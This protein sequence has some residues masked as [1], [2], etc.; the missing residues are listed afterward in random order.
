MET[1]HLQVPI[2][3]SQSIKDAVPFV[4]WAGG[5]RNIIT[6]LISRLPAKI[7]D[8]YEPFVG[9]GAL[10]FKIYNKVRKS[11]LS[12]LN[13][14]LVITY[15]VI[16]NNPQKLL[17][18]LEIHKKNHN[19]EYYYKVRA[20]HNL[21]ATTEI[22]ARFFYL[23]KTCFNGVYRVNKKGK[24]NVPPGHLGNK[25]RKVAN[26]IPVKNI[27]FCS[28]ALENTEISV[29][30]FVNIE[31]SENDFVYFDPPYYPVKNNSF[32]DYTSSGF[33]EADQ[34]RLKDFA[35]ELTHRKVNVMLSNSYA[36]FI[37]DLYKN[38]IFKKITIEAPRYIN[39]EATKRGKVKE[40]LITNY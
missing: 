19:K 34:I 2:W 25:K 39:A 40:L 14:E 15:N 26:I 30:D 3:Q 23:N 13:S 7:N 4:K 18:A 8:Y 32:K 12:D 21:T 28:S 20:Q 37:L 9:G 11:Y 24:F 6:E 27:E 16:K 1:K 36:P 22:A 35:I 38:K 5:K 31:P 10:F 33:S 17:E 29:K